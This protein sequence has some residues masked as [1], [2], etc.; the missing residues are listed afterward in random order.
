MGSQV[1]QLRPDID[2]LASLDPVLLDTLTKNAYEM[3]SIIDTSG[4][5]LFSGGALEAI[6]GFTPEDRVGRNVTEFVH[7]DD[8]DY[9][10][11]RTRQF[12]D[13]PNTP[14]HSDSISARLRHKDGSFRHVEITGTRLSRRGTPALVVVHTRDVTQ[15][16]RAL[17]RSAEAQLQVDVALW[18]G[19][20]MLWQLDL[21]TMSLV[22]SGRGSLERRGIDPCLGPN[23]ERRWAEQIHSEDLPRVLDHYARQSSGE[24]SRLELE[25]RVRSSTGAWVWLQER[26]QIVARNADG[27]ASRVAGVCVCID[28]KR[29]LQQQLDDANE[30]LRLAVESSGIAAW[31]WDVNGDRVRRNRE[32]YELLGQTAPPEGSWTETNT[33]AR[34]LAHPDDRPIARAAVAAVLSGAEPDFQFEARRS[35]RPVSGAGREP[36]ASVIERNTD[37]TPR[38]IVGTMQDVHARRCAEEALRA[39]EARHRA[40]SSLRRGYVIDS[41]YGPDGTELSYWVSPGFED[42]FGCT[43]ERFD[44]LGG[45]QRFV[46][47]DD[48]EHTLRLHR[49][50]QPGSS[51]E[52]VGRIIRLDGEVRRICGVHQA[53]VDPQSNGRRLLSSVY[54][55]TEMQPAT[56]EDLSL[57]ADIIENV[58]ACIV[59]L[60]SELQIRFATRSLLDQ[61]SEHLRGQRLLSFFGAEWHEQIR[62]AFTRSEREARNIEIEGVVPAAPHA[63][64]RRYRLHIAPAVSRDRGSQWCVVIRD[65]SDEL[66]GESRAFHA[67][68]QDHQRIGH[69]LREGVGQ[70]LAGV[71]MLL[72]SLAAQLAR[73]GHPLSTEAG[74]IAALINHSV[75]DVRALSRSLS[76]VGV[77]P[78][79]LAVALEGLV[80]NAREVGKLTVACELE[81]SAGHTICPVDADHLY[82]I[83]QEAVSNVLRHAQAEN[84]WIRLFASPTR[85]ELEVGDDGRG[86]ADV[87]ISAGTT[88]G[89]ALM[90]HRAR[91]IGATLSFGRREPRGT[92]IRCLRITSN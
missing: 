17:E 39:S 73:Q 90:T 65:I 31:D 16:T 53:T 85:L 54:D 57:Q 1:A 63:T 92:S 48:Y 11:M 44:E 82:G 74:Q 89:L 49:A 14:D 46:H 91:G 56:G 67:L 23:S 60:N 18:G 79:G 55:I 38:R 25:Y 28:E 71:A 88:H 30:R 15:E 59:L 62:D 81:V 78:T 20:L 70:Q 47:P 4:R 27:T 13:D 66:D 12:I 9:V 5:I 76:P 26:A 33:G 24:L 29:Q 75:D 19:D 40:A 64:N 32:W 34:E 43:K 80:E 52:V 51:I 36:A 2:P 21:H 8:A 83:I 10:H 41:T 6:T 42:L 45:W 84:L 3:V 77:A 86:L 50:L 87:A 68:G 37:G 72:Q 22:A 7:P 61:P 35:M 69:D 58:P